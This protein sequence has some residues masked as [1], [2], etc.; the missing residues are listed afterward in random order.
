MTS[1]KPSKKC[2]ESTAN[3]L[4]QK[5]LKAQENPM[6]EFKEKVD[7]RERFVLGTGEERKLKCQKNALFY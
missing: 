7:R 5:N 2:T 3:D 6:I 4:W 1:R